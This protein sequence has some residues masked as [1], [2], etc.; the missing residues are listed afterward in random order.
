MAKYGTT[1][2]HALVQHQQ[3]IQRSLAD[4]ASGRNTEHLPAT[5]IDQVI[6]ALEERLETIKQSLARAA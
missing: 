6:R 1:S 3:I 2:V 4:F 5:E